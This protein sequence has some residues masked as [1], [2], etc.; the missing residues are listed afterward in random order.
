M[1]DYLN[2]MDFSQENTVFNTGMY[3]IDSSNVD[4]VSGF[5]SDTWERIDFKRLSKFQNES[6]L[7]HFDLLYLIDTF[8]PSAG[9]G[10]LTEQERQWLADHPS[11]RLGIDV[12]SPPFEQ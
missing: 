7:Y 2:A 9:G 5:L 10:T 6:L 3:A 8:Y 11:I 1:Y 12:D 4:Q